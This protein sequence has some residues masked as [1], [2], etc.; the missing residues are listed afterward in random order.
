MSVVEAIYRTLVAW[1]LEPINASL[2]FAL[3]FVL[4]WFGILWALYRRNIFLKV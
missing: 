1:G 3:S 4:L 2:A